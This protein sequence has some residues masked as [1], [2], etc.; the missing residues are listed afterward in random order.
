MDEFLSVV[1][2]LAFLFNSLIMLAIIPFWRVL[3]A[4]SYIRIAL[5]ASNFYFAYIAI[6]IS[7][8]CE[9]CNGPVSTSTIFMLIGIATAAAGAA[10]IIFENELCERYDL[11]VKK[12]MRDNQS[13]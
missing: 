9:Q 7:I 6:R 11:N 13:S 1:S 3:H 10:L 8:V 4:S 2:N 12:I 5:A